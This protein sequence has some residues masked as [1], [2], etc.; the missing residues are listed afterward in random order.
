VFADLDG[1]RLYYTDTGGDIA[2]LGIHGGMGIDGGTLRV[3]PILAL[4]D[5]GIRVIIPDQRGHGRSLAGDVNALSH[6]QWTED[7]RK[8]AVRLGLSRFALLGHSYGGFLALEFATRWPELLT[9]LILIGTSAGP[10]QVAAAHID[11]D[12]DLKAHFRER[13]SEFFV[14]TNKHWEVFQELHFSVDAYNA[15]FQREL[16][17]YDVRDRIGAIAAPTLLL[18]GEADW[19]LPEMHWLAQHL[20]SGSLCIIPGAGHFMFLEK[21]GEFTR[22]V[23]EFLTARPER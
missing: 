3:Q 9:H 22:M 1:T 17:K 4:A 21:P 19:Y 16:P 10:R 8:L 5:Y 11:S 20:P 15:A 13:W 2:L 23:A 18:S 12:A 7:V 6:T 14:G